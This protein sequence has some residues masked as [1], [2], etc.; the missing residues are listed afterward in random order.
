LQE[1]VEIKAEPT[2]FASTGWNGRKRGK[3]RLTGLQ[4]E[5]H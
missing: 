3:V 4:A 5:L 2:H 1:M